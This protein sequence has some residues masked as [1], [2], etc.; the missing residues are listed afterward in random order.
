VG[1]IDNAVSVL[2]AVRI[3][4]PRELVWQV[5]ADVERQPEWMRDALS[6]EILT[7]GPVGVGTRLRV[8]TQILFLRTTDLLEVTAFEPPQRWRV[9]HRGLVTGE[10]EFVLRET[11]DERGAATELEWHERLAAPLGA[12]GRIGMSA[13]KPL[14]RRVFA[15]DLERLRAICEAK[16]A[17]T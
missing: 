1:A 12:L 15:A 11:D 9:L 13:M 5:L 14:L 3:R 16:A 10:G 17:A 6:V 7:P 2:T 4:A 8:P